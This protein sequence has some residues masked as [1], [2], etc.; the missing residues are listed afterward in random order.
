MILFLPKK[1]K[2]TCERSMRH[3][4]Q[5]MGNRAAISDGFVLFIAILVYVLVYIVFYFIFSQVGLSIEDELI[6]KKATLDTEFVL[7]NYLRTPVPR[8]GFATD[9]GQTVADLVYTA[10]ETR[11]TVALENAT[12]IIFQ[13]YD[14]RYWRL[15]VYK[16]ATPQDDSYGVNKAFTL[17]N[18]KVYAPYTSMPRAFAQLPHP[19]RKDYPAISVMLELEAEE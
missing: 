4:N 15:Q 9:D 7:R 12:K 3:K 14:Q 18:K 11:D 2:H 1:R 5:S 19:N 17:Y 6:G 8:G 10:V 13:P 16:T